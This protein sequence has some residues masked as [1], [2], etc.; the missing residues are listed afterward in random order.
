MHNPSNKTRIEAHSAATLRIRPAQSVSLTKLKRALELSQLEPV[1]SWHSR[2]VYLP[3]ALFG[4]ICDALEGI[5]LDIA[6]EVQLTHRSALDQ[7]ALLKR[8]KEIIA[9]FTA[10]GAARQYL[11]DFPAIDVLD[12]HQIDAV[13]I[14]THPDVPGFCL[15]DEQGLGKTITTLFS[16]HR[17]RQKEMVSAMLVLCPKNMVLEWQ[18][19][20]ARFFHG[21][22]K[23]QTVL[24]SARQ[25]RLTLNNQ[26]DLYITNFETP[27]KLFLRLKALLESERGGFLL[28]VDESFYVKNTKALR[29]RAVR[30]L[31]ESAKR[32]IVLCG[33]P[34]PNRPH[35]LVE[36]FNTADGGVAF[37]GITL[38][39]DRAEALPIVQQVLRERGVYLRR[40][41]Q[42]ALPN[43]PT[44]LF[45]R[46]I[47]PLQPVQLELYSQALE[48]LINELEHVSDE[49]FKREMVSFLA[50]RTRLMQI[51][52]NPVGVHK[53]YC[54]VP[55]KLL[56]LDALLEE[57]VKHRGEKVIVWSYFT[58]SL[59]AVLARFAKFNPVR[60]DGKVPDAGVRRQAI[61]RFQ[62]DD[63]TMIF[64]GNLAAAAAGLTLHRARY[65]IYE[66]LSN[67]GAHYFQ[68][69]DRIHRRGQTRPVEYI[70]LLTDRT[71]EQSE[72]ARLAMKEQ[73]A[74]SLLGDQVSRPV[75]RTEMLEEA[76]QAAVVLGQ[77]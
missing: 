46:V 28:A 54:E 21:A 4:T 63:S 53:T 55:A 51:C 41:K 76:R 33:T 60:F 9:M 25:K 57:L 18:R 26:A 17:L 8:G 35:D 16:F 70:I 45:Q 67:Q 66:S 34:A 7:E 37:R 23:C 58:A 74:Q 10:P 2:E 11:S 30:K 43:L 64:A 32:C 36:Q 24:G 59:E 48:G 39:A 68:S 3:A 15:F 12:S 69:L 71:I 62:E 5:D 20:A 22:Y 19:D 61:T 27:V 44:R 73:M 31:R 47:V 50:K 77:R 6:P 13:A 29:S 1:V 40:L 72:Y 52:S 65:A 49:A 42:D 38:P 56:A 75:T 14:A